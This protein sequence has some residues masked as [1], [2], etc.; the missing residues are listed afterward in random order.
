MRDKQEAPWDP[1]NGR[2]LHVVT[3]SEISRNKFIHPKWSTICKCS[4]RLLMS[5]HTGPQTQD[6]HQI[7]LPIFSWKGGC[8]RQLQFGPWGLISTD[9]GPPENPE[10]KPA[11]FPP[12]IPA[13]PCSLLFLLL[14]GF[15]TDHTYTT[16]FKP[17]TALGANTS[18]T[19]Q[20]FAPVEKNLA[21][22]FNRHRRSCEVSTT[23]TSKV[24]SE[25]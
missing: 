20:P 7:Q 18:I 9:L 13:Q 6:F 21:K 25:V 22:L 8:L 2:Q 4:F 24:N 5:C 23:W 3:Q 17:L 16:S 10:S 15:Q 12:L 11:P 1:K 14:P 19:Q